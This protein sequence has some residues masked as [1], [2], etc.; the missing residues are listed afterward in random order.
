MLAV[1]TGGKFFVWLFFYNDFLDGDIDQDRGEEKTVTTP[2]DPRPVPVVPK[3]KKRPWSPD[4]HDK[5]PV[6]KLV[7]SSARQKRSRYPSSPGPA[8]APKR[9]CLSPVPSCSYTYVPPP[10]P[11]SKNFN[12]MDPL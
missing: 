8:L 11:K 4:L 10:A 2:T 3:G 5:S 12:R 1:V 6:R 7:K 9:P